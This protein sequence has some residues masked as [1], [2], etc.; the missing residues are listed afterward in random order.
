MV[1]RAEKPRRMPSPEAAARRLAAW[2]RRNRRELPWRGVKDPYRIWVSEVMLQQ[3]Q[4]A[5]VVPHYLGFLTRFPSLISLAEASEEQVL[6][7]WSGL[8]Y[9]R[10]AR[11]LHAAAR[12]VLES[13]GGKLPREVKSLRRLPG[14]GAYTAGALASIAFERPE[15]ALDGNAERV[16]SRLLSCPG[17]SGRKATRAR[18]EAMVRSMMR[19]EPPSEITQGLMELG[20]L[21][22]IPAKPQCPRCPLASLCLARERG[23]QHLLP[24]RR[25]ERS[26]ERMQAALAILKN[27]KRYLLWRRNRGELMEGLWEFPGGILGDRERAPDALRRWGRDRL[28]RTILAGGKATT[29]TQS[30]TY[31]RIQVSA[32]EARLGEASPPGWRLPPDA[33]WLTPI[34]I[35][36][37]PHGSATRKVL[38]CLRERSGP[39]R[40]KRTE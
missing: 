36:R 17:D 21:I 11:G 29:F 25:Q 7:A 32:Y 28:G 18:F 10:R 31:R 12:Q 1:A 6:S 35:S 4:V 9:Y 24:P 14:I 3:T 39:A 23:L 13:H 22:C 27:G 8:G 38:A 40:C 20:A 19:A 26:P 16:L 33:R 37:M 30:I 2:Y 5:T 15:P 34:Q